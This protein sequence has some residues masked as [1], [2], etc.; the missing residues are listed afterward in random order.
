MNQVSLVIVK[1]VVVLVIAKSCCEIKENVNTLISLSLQ[2][3][4]LNFIKVKFSGPAQENTQS[5]I[6][7][8]FKLF[9]GEEEYLPETIKCKAR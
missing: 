2:K 6:I 8:L 5:I 7:R 4:P 9:S 3:K 1:I